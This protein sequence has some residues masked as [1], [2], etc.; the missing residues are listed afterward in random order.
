MEISE[1]KT[2]LLSDGNKYLVLKIL[3]IES[4]EY[5]ITLKI[6]NGGDIL[7]FNRFENKLK[8]VDDESTID[9]VLNTLLNDKEFKTKYTENY[10]KFIELLKHKK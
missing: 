5:I 6:T 8:V 2:I 3:K 10:K 4:N 7:V 1:N 9:L